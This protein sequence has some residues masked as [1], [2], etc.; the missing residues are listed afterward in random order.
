MMLALN[1]AV[2]ALPTVISAS[3]VAGVAVG[4][5]A[6]E[7]A[8]RRLGRDALPTRLG[9]GAAAGLVVGLVVAALVVTGYGSGASVVV[10]AAGVGAA[11]LI[12]GLF[13]VV[14]PAGVVGA[15]V[16]GTLAWFLLGLLQGVLNDQL[17][18]LFGAGGSAA[19]R[20]HATSRLLLTVAVSGGIIAG[21]SAYRYLRP[22]MAGLGW[23]AYL[24]AG[25]GPGLLLLLANLLALAAGARLRTL[26]E[27]ASAAD[28][29]ALRYIGTA[30]LDTALILLFV[31]AVTAMIAYG[32]TLKAPEAPREV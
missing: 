1:S 10:I 23:P 12:G 22:R 29:V 4:F 28:S 20:V 11:S 17:L 16:T 3:M 5:V 2:L 9:A 13:S 32:R 24:A 7:Y 18:R 8:G 30:G 25:A 27:A 15:A 31:G 26:A 6:V 14:R 19:S 21:L